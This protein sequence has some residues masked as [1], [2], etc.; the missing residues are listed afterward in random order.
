VSEPIHPKP[1]EPLTIKPIETV[2]EVSR[3]LQ[4]GREE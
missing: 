3:M 4:F 2:E 1:D